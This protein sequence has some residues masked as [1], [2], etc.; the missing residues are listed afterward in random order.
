MKSKE[1]RAPFIWT[2][3]QAINRDLGFR[4]LLWNGAERRDDG[5]NR[6]VLFRRRFSLTSP[7]AHASLDMTVDGRYQL[8]TNGRRLG[9]GPVR[10]NPHYQRYDTYDIAPDLAVGENV[11]AVLVHVY[12]V[13]TAW[14]ETVKGYWQ[15]F[16]GDGGL[17]CDAG[18]QC[19]DNT[20]VEVLSDTSWRSQVCA[21]W[22]QDTPRAGWGQGFI[23]DFDANKMPDDW[24][25]VDFDDESW[26][27]VQIL[28]IPPERND[29]AKGWRAPEPFS[30]LMVN[31]LPPMAETLVEPTRVIAQFGVM[32]SPEQPLD[33]R[34]YD[35]E[36]ADLPAGSVENAEALLRDDAA[37]TTVRTLPD[38][39]VSLFL[40]FEQLHSGYPFIEID[41]Q[42]GEV[43][44]M[45]V[46]ETF[47]GEFDAQW[48]A[49][50]RLARVSYLDCAH[51]FRYT[52]RPGVQRYEKFEWTAVRY[53]QIV[54]RNAPRG[55]KIRH[56]GSIHTHY[57][58][59]Y[60]GAYEC[61]DEFLN[62]LWRTGRYTVQ[63]CT[64]DA[65]EDCPGREKRQWLG[66][67]I[68]HYLAA[69]AAFGPSS[70]PVDRKFLYDGA[71]SQRPDGLMQMF[72]PGDHHTN[73]VII[74]DFNLHWIGAL[75]HYFLH[76]GDEAT[77]EELFPAA[78]RAISWF[79][80]QM[81]PDSL[82]ASVPFWH[83]IEWADVGRN[84]QGAII[85][86]MFAGA[87]KMAAALAGWLDMPRPKKR[88][89]EL[90]GLIAVS[91]N[92][93]HWDVRRGVYV[94]MVDP[95]T[96]KQNM[97]VS[98]HAN[99]AMILWDIAPRDRWP[100]MIAYI[101]DPS[102]AKLTSVPPIVMHGE[103]FDDATDV[104]EANT[105]FSHFV[106]AALAKAGRFDL[107]L[108]AIRKNYQPMLATD[109]ATLWEG[110]E[111]S[112]SL[113]HAFSASPLYQLSAHSLGVQPI[114]PGF[115]DFRLA[116]QPADLT[117]ARGIYSTV[118]GDIVVS[119]RREGRRLMF[120][121]T[122]PDGTT[123]EMVS[124][125]GYALKSGKTRLA[126]GMHTVEL[127]KVAT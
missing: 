119:W 25:A 112:A 93:R 49:R 122:V 4:Q 97:R 124:P 87:L 27:G 5:V 67:G 111:P 88:Y 57:P 89:T 18:I 91:L 99:A 58:L 84:G 15:P 123:A 7:A 59:A 17:Y 126:P 31:D 79:E 75:Y 3:R 39:D 95:A 20:A 71:H 121:A 13:D 118:K 82:L 16:Y 100:A 46:S 113:C 45:G 63:E 56:A 14:Y 28:R 74:P 116:P 104:V 66:D 76:T 32:P 53:M 86:A 47:A 11:I 102:R 19:Q 64:H 38:R 78:E 30:C 50:P 98:Q 41:A 34:L 68:V 55:L 54:V 69:A 44:E 73:G 65:W 43:I 48:P 24:T 92:A 51:L 8:F 22:R 36:L 9:R 115:H 70:Q 77:V 106:N 109:T 120:E 80:R 125:P 42:G 72:A 37:M 117:R 33:R 21:A 96:G 94:D 61:N 62:R 60:G 103:S 52:A 2:P 101:T 26:D 23:E 114:S 35:E 107:A 83:F 85:N 108:T 10:S 1:R 29:R 90:A 40:C 81:G 105:Y 110:Y 127:T 6:W 12:G